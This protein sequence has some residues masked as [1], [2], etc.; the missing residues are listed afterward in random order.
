ME[1]ID[2]GKKI[3]SGIQT[4]NF[5]VLKNFALLFEFN[6]GLFTDKVGWIKMNPNLNHFCKFQNSNS[7]DTNEKPTRSMLD[8]GNYSSKAT[9]LQDVKI[10]EYRLV[11]VSE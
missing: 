1:R 10:E 5:F 9:T 6:F 3:N 8:H 11:G 7:S 4:L 2:V